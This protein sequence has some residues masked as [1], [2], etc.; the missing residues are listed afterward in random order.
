VEE[1]NARIGEKLLQNVALP[2]ASIAQLNS[3]LS[4]TIDEND[5]NKMLLIS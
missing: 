3:S 5:R 1:E 4:M 2:E